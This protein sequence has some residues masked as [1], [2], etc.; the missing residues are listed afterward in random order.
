MK[1]IT[2]SRPAKMDWYDQELVERSV[3]QQVIIEDD[4]PKDTGLFDVT[5][6]KIY[7]T[8]DRIPPGF[9]K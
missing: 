1:Y 2:I 7:R 4:N 6:T 3:G 5:G 8:S 9:R